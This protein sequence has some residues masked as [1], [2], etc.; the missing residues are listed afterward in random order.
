MLAFGGVGRASA[1]TSKVYLEVRGL[2]LLSVSEIDMV[3]FPTWEVGAMEKVPG[4][5]K[6]TKV[7]VYPRVTKTFQVSPSGS[8]ID[9]RV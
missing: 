9:G 4:L 7:D 1:S 2:G 8:V 5:V 6:V 3:K